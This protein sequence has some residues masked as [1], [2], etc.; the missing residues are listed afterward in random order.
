MKLE[1]HVMKKRK[2]K[3]PEHGSAQTVMNPTWNHNFDRNDLRWCGT[4][5]NRID[6][7]SVY[8]LLS[9]HDFILHSGAVN[10]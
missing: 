6:P 4:P 3:D 10:S 7:K 8:I 1:Y 5:D 9:D 2:E